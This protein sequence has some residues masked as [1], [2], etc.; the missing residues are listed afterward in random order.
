MSNLNEHVK[1]DKV[2]WV[3]TLLVGLLLIGAIIGLFIKFDRQ[4]STTTIGGEAYSIGLIDDTGANESGDTAIY[5]REAVTTD[6]LTC[7]LA[8]DAKISYQLFYYDADG[9]FLSA[10]DVLTADFD[11]SDI[12]EGAESVRIVITPISDEDGKVSLHEVLVY[13]SRLTVTI[14]R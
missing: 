5:L 10:S 2:K 7:K 4:T 9:E 12:P 6:G 14:N 8:K 13:A 3:I 1:S 11:G